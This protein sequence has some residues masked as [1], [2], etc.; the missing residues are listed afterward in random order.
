MR[1]SFIYMMIKL[2][3]IKF[4]L[5]FE[6]R[7]KETSAWRA[8]VSFFDLDWRSILYWSMYLL[9]LT[10][11]VRGLRW[12]IGYTSVLEIEFRILPFVVETRKIELTPTAQ[13]VSTLRTPDG[14]HSVLPRLMLRG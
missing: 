14:R 2:N 11:V 13:V 7:R 12:N 3:L 5:M 6:I 4:Y 9:V 1:F 10:N 8:L